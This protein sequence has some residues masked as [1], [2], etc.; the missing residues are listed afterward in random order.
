MC[1]LLCTHCSAFSHPASPQYIPDPIF[2]SSV[3]GALCC[4][5]VMPFMFLFDHVSD[6]LLFCFALQRKRDEDKP[7]LVQELGALTARTWQKVW[8]TSR[9]EDGDDKD[10]KDG[11]KNK[12]R[13]HPAHQLIKH[14]PPAVQAFLKKAAGKAPSAVVPE[15]KEKSG[16]A[17]GGFSQGQSDE[18]QGRS[19]VGFGH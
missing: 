11:D 5:V 10:D 3:A 17:C 8:C 16:R 2:I 19:C 13:E 14:Q 9:G 7:G 12:P 18:K 4:M 1:W 6:T 15:N